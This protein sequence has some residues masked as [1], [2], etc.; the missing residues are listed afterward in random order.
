MPRTR[1][2]SIRTSTRSTSN[3]E[4][5]RAL[6]RALLEVTLFWVDHGVRA[7]RVDNPHTKTFAF[8]EWLIANVHAASR[9]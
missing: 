4:D 8:W 6:W 7:F 9:T 3:R 5:W 2:R 1:R